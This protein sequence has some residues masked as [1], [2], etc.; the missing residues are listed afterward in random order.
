MF[1]RPLP[2]SPERIKA[3]TAVTG[4]VTGPVLLDGKA[5]KT[6]VIKSSKKA[7]KKVLHKIRTA[8]VV[9]PFHGKLTADAEHRFNEVFASG[10]IIECG[11]NAHGRRKLRDAEAT[12][13]VLAA[14]GGRFI[15]AMYGELKFTSSQQ[16]PE[17]RDQPQLC[18]NPVSAG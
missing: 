15:G 11:C 12:Q 2:L 18:C 16:A 8:R 13:P 9:K 3:A 5:V 4:G 10:E 1:T 17:P 6:R 14:E 7:A